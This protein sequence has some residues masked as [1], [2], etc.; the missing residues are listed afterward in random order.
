MERNMRGAWID[1][2]AQIFVM[3]FFHVGCHFSYFWIVEF[4]FKWFAVS[5]LLALIILPSDTF[6]KWKT[7]PVDSADFGEKGFLSSPKHV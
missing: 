4:L 1:I 5:F 2:S 3:I 7:S 6:A